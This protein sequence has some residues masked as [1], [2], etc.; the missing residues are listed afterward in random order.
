MRAIC[1]LCARLSRLRFGILLL[2]R[3]RFR[4]SPS[5][6]S[7]PAWRRLVCLG[8]MQGGISSLNA[9]G[10]ANEDIEKPTEEYSFAGSGKSKSIPGTTKMLRDWERGIKGNLKVVPITT[11]IFWALA[12]RFVLRPTRRRLHTQIVHL[13]GK[14]WEAKYAN[15]KSYIC[16]VL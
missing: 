6:E 14:T 12:R 2:S 9:G 15:I 7:S 8:C 1:G 11:L 10:G 5:L 3:L 4:F 16:Q 13:S